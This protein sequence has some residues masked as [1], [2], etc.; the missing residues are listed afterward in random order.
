MLNP[1]EMIRIQVKDLPKEASEPKMV[2]FMYIA[3]SASGSVHE[4]LTFVNIG[5]SG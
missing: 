3:P 4:Y 1:A 5:V 2:V